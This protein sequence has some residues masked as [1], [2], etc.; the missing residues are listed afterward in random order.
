MPMQSEPWRSG[1][2]DLVWLSDGKT[3]RRRL[4]E[5]DETA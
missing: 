4:L 3:V 5:I 2:V 1:G